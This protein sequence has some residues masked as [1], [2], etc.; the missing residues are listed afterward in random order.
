MTF[1]LNVRLDDL[2]KSI[3]YVHY[4]ISDC[5]QQ[6][7]DVRLRKKIFQKNKYV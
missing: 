7:A 6:A 4:R 5:G 1:Q 2:F 3:L